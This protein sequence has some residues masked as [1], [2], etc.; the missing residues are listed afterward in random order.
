MGKL[1]VV[2]Y[3]NQ[4]FAQVGGGEKADYPVEL[5]RGR[6]RWTGYW[7]CQQAFGDEAEIVGDHRLR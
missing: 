5:P 4:F 6:D 3:I 1:R 2:H 7:R